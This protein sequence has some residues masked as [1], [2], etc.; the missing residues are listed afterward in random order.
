[1]GNVTKEHSEYWDCFDKFAQTPKGSELVDMFQTYS[2]NMDM[3]PEPKVRTG[4]IVDM[5]LTAF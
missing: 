2:Y 3:F 1:M 5:F 4:K